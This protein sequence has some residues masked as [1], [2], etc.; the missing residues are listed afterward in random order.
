MTAIVNW[1]IKVS[2]LLAFSFGFVLTLC[3]TGHAQLAGN[4]ESVVTVPTDDPFPESSFLTTKKELGK[5][6]LVE[7]GAPCDILIS[8]SDYPGVLKIA[9]LFRKD[10][11]NVSGHQAR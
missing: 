9:E 10:L 1:H 3:D 2:R 4:V 6:A 5:F 8:E 11:S 7:N